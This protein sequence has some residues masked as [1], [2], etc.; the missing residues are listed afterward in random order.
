MELKRKVAMVAATLSMALGAGHI[1]QNGFGVKPG[2]VALVQEPA[3]AP[4]ITPTD[5]PKEIIPLAA[6]LGSAPAPVPNA[7]PE[8]VLPDTAFAPPPEPAISPPVEQVNLPNLNAPEADGPSE[9]ETLLSG[10]STNCPVRLSV[11]ANAQA[12]LD[13]TL[14]APCRASQRVV[15][16]HGGLA[17]TAMTTMTGSLFTSIPGMDSAGEVSVLFGD[18]VEVN[19]AEPLSDL[20]LYR[21]FAVQWLADDA[22]QINAF[23]NGAVFGGEGHVSAANPQRRLANVPMESGYL[24]LLGDAT[25]PLPMLAEVYTFPLDPAELV[26]LTIE[27]SVT[28]ATCDR[29]L[30]GEVLLSEAGKTTKTD[31][32]MATPTCDAIGDVLVL[33]NPLPD[34]KLAAAN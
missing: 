23:E 32:T 13:L 29:E 9:Q 15:I 34:L 22:F 7:Q 17:V 8:P 19:A 2:R 26:D 14:V 6:G 27:A 30:L 1:M 12:T 10:D 16:R 28:A 31:L 4:A 18:S 24:D 20:A 5:A 25:A 33:N 3:T 11:M 21:R